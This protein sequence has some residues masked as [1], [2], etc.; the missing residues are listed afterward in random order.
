MIT[1]DAL[2][3]SLDLQN[4]KIDRIIMHEITERRME[5]FEEDLSEFAYDEDDIDLPEEADYSAIPQT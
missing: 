2:W 1:A 4:N 3:E 5:G